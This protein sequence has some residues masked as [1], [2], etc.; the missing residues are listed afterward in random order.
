M[1][2]WNPSN[3]E[4]YDESG[5]LPVKYLTHTSLSLGSVGVL[6]VLALAGLAC[7]RRRRR[8]GTADSY[9]PTPRS[10]YPAPVTI[11]NDT[12]TFIGKIPQLQARVSNLDAKIYQMQQ[13]LDELSHL[14]TT[15]EELQKK[16]EDLACLL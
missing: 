2:E 8:L 5:P 1:K 10:R 6:G 4:I 14:N 9:P 12:E 3:E 13:K 7:C 11:P 16:Y 15:L